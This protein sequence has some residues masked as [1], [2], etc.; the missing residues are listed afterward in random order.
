MTDV[1]DEL[2]RCKKW[3]EDA[4]AYSGGTHTFNDV[5]DAVMQGTMQL[6]PGQKS[7]AV[8]E[9]I[10]YPQ[11]KTIHVFLAGG[12]KDE[13]IRMQ[14]S[15]AAWGR[16]QGCEH[17]TLAGRKGWERELKPHGWTHLCTTLKVKI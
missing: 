14:Q 3:I 9:I 17:M 7:C 11:T 10:K 8:T 13:I 2:T 16:Q 5:S 1:N 15:A 4:L 12:D 6:W